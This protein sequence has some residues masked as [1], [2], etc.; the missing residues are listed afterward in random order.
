MREL[1]CMRGKD[2]S[3]RLLA[4]HQYDDYISTPKADAVRSSLSES[5]EIR[6]CGIK[7]MLWGN[8]GNVPLDVGIL[9]SHGVGKSLLVYKGLRYGLFSSF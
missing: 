2:Q 5:E 7:V 9:R 8:M 4:L 3:G 1:S 6:S